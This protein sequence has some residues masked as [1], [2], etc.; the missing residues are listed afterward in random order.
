[1]SRVKADATVIWG[2]CPLNPLDEVN[3]PTVSTGWRKTFDHKQKSVTLN[4]QFITIIHFKLLLF[5]ADKKHLL[6]KL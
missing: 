3:R 2:A 4:W 5:T 1:M 6:H